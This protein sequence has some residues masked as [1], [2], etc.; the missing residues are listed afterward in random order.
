MVIKY[1][2]VNYGVIITHIYTNNT[3]LLQTRNLNSCF[4]LNRLLLTTT[5]VYLIKFPNIMRS[6]RH[7]TASIIFWHWIL[8]PPWGSRGQYSR[9]GPTIEYNPNALAIWANKYGIIRYSGINIRC[10]YRMKQ[11]SMLLLL[12]PV[13]LASVSWDCRFLN[14]LRV[15][16][17]SC[18]SLRIE[19][20]Y[21]WTKGQT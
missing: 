17:W 10:T 2:D 20:W 11:H 1:E 13:F 5:K 12:L 15:D 4:L 7:E 8:L 21:R 18:L 3:G 14:W 16:K 6:L 9:S 19:R